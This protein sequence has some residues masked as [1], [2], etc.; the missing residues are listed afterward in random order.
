M[1]LLHRLRQ[2]LQP[3]PA[4]VSAPLPKASQAV[5]LEPDDLF[6][7][8]VAQAIRFHLP[9]QSFTLI[10]NQLTINGLTLTCLVGDRQQHP[11]AVVYGLEVRAY[12][13]AYFPNGLVDCLAGIGTDDADALPRPPITT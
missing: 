9:E 7:A 11:Q 10:G 3:A 6:S 12:Q 1:S 5:E 2:L 8:Q 4:I 13:A